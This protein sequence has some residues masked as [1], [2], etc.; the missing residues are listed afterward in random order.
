[1]IRS[2]SYS[3]LPTEQSNPRTRRI[4]KASS[5]EIVR[6]INREDAMTAPAVLREAGNIARAIDL[7]AD[8]LKKGGRLFFAGAGTSG[9]L[10]VLEAAECP[11]TFGTP[12]SLVQAVVAG[13]RRAVFR[14]R[15]GAEDDEADARKRIG[16]LARKGDV[17][18]GISASGVT[19]FTLAALKEAGRRGCAT[20][21]V[22]SNE[23]PD[24]KG[25]GAI[26]CP[27]V[28]PEVIAGSTRLKSATAAKMVLNMLT[29][30]SMIKL[31]K[32]YQNWMVDLQP[33][34][35]KLRIRAIGLVSYL[36]RVSAKRA[37]GL[38]EKSRWNVRQA[39]EA[40]KS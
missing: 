28:G 37:K 18:V 3:R 25:V 21:L 38:L 27:I 33:V 4:D 16:A 22:T 35:R 8:G 12:P 29:A 34:S 17:V 7:I 19:P 30:A 11:P 40:A 2:R 15:E 31:G 36:G 13:G 9:R 32:V 5:L 26:I 14:S 24:L 6:L 10:G 23:R 39:I 1:M 20:V